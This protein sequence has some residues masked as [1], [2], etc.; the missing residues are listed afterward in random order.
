LDRKVHQESPS[1]AVKTHSS[2]RAYSR[3]SYGSPALFPTQSRSP[4]PPES[5]RLINKIKREEMEDDA[6]MRR[7]S[8]QTAAML[9]EAREALGSKFEVGG[10][11]T[12]DFDSGMEDGGW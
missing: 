9:R 12:M 4:L 6:R 10:G 2:P 11:S 5:Q 3:Q 8:A 1:G 7:M